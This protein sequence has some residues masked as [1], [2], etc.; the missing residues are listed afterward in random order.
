MLYGDL[1]LPL[2]Q[3]EN[4]MGWLLQKTGYV[5]S[6]MASG[7]DFMIVLHGGSNAGD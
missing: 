6:G 2:N 5:F 7:K 4:K 1:N 3:Q